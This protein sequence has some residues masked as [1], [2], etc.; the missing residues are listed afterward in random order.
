MI[1]LVNFEF[2]CKDKIGSI[3][4]HS[5]AFFALVCLHFMTETHVLSVDEFV[6]SVDEVFSY[7]VVDRRGMRP[8]VR[9]P[10]DVASNLV[11]AARGLAGDVDDAKAKSICHSTEQGFCFAYHLLDSVVVFG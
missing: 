11:I 7:S 8:T 3:V 10:L 4:N 1:W 9:V 5:R 2:V 6:F